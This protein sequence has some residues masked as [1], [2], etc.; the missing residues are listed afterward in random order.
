MFLREKLNYDDNFAL[1]YGNLS[2][3]L[4]EYKSQINT[5]FFVKKMTVLFLFSAIILTNGCSRRY[6]NQATVTEAPCNNQIRSQLFEKEI[7]QNQVAGRFSIS[8]DND[9]NEVQL[10]DS[11][12][13]VGLFQ[14]LTIADTV[15]G[16]IHPPKI[17]RGRSLILGRKSLPNGRERFFVSNYLEAANQIWMLSFDREFRLTGAFPISGS[18]RNSKFEINY[19]SIFNTDTVDIQIL[20]VV[21]CQNKHADSICSSIYRYTG[22]IF[23]SG[24]VVLT[25]LFLE[26]KDSCCPPKLGVIL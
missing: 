14:W 3:D 19:E 24:Q 12:E 11:C 5:M 2:F 7:A 23:D 9:L 1:F 17:R 22:H 10:L 18:F 13:F 4:T 21:A 8:E 16:E 26:V 6:D 25:D 20:E 15:L